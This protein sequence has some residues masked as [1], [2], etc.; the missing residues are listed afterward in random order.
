ME[1]ST[2]LQ[3]LKSFLETQ[4]DQPL[5][6]AC[7]LNNAKLFIRSLENANLMYHF[8]DDA[9]DCLANTDASINLI[10]MIQ[11]YVD[12]ILFHKSIH[13]GSHEDP[14][15]YAIF[16]GSMPNNFKL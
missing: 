5:R 9:I 14:Y 4:L 8:D 16:I 2:S 1:K 12:C 3:T 13:W 15:G 7:N 6:E 11:K 10:D